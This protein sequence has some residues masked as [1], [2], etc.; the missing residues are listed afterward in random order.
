[1]AI[2]EKRRLTYTSI[3]VAVTGV[4]TGLILGAALFSGGDAPS[5]SSPSDGTADL[6]AVNCIL[7]HGQNREGIANL[8]PALTQQSVAELSDAEIRDT[9]SAGRIAKGMPSWTGV[10]SAAEIDALV[11]FIRSAAP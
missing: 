7:C 2:S 3:A 10:L 5:V 9:I 4:V 6:Y 8:G 11:Q 1:V